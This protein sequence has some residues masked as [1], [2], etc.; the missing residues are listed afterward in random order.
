MKLL[1][2]LLV[3][4]HRIEHSARQRESM[5]EDQSWLRSVAVRICVDLKTIGGGD[6]VAVVRHVFTCDGKVNDVRG[7]KTN[8]IRTLIYCRSTR[9]AL[10]R[11]TT[12]K[13]VVVRNEAADSQGC[14]Q[15]L[16]EEFACAR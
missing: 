8:I 15:I 3:R 4:K 2:K 5:D 6:V 12:S 7:A 16:K 10:A 1:R 11:S 13:P 9:N 14:R